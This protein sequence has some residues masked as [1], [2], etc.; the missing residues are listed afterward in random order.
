[1]PVQSSLGVAGH[2]ASLR[3]QLASALQRDILT[4]VYAPGQRLIE[5]ELVGRFGVSSIPVR[6]ALQDLEGQGLVVK[7][8]NVG[9]KVIDLTR[10]EA[11]QICRLRCVLEPQV[12]RW[13]A[14]CFT[15]EAAKALAERVGEMRAA[16]AAGDIAAFFHAD[17]MF[18]KALWVVAGNRWASHALETALGSLFASG[19]MA[20][21]RRGTLNLPNEADKHHELVQL[22]RQGHVEAAAGQMADIAGRFETEVL[23]DM[24]SSDE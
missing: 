15:E 14:E 12:V 1:M 24:R 3:Q 9:C 11:K 6:E 19:L 20:A 17:M 7:R 22:L 23:P 2:P 5:R 16:A 21:L 13:A 8:P 18:H 4:G 10:E